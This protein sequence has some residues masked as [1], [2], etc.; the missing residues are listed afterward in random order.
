[1]KEVNTESATELKNLL[2]RLISGLDD[3]LPIARR[4]FLDRREQ[5][6]VDDAAAARDEARAMELDNLLVAL[7]DEA[8]SD[9]LDA[10]DNALEAIDDAVL[11]LQK[12]G[13][14]FTELRER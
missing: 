8:A 4:T 14:K 5:L 7:V 9:Q 11:T 2:R 12:A 13:D 6:A 10:I 1:V 3:V